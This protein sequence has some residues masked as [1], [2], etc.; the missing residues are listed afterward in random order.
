MTERTVQHGNFTIERHYDVEPARVFEAFADSEIKA[1]WACHDDWGA[2]EFDFS[3]GGREVSRGG[4]PGG[5]V[6]TFDAR[7]HDIVPQRRIIF[8]YDMYRDDTR[9]SVSVAT[10][11]FSPAG[12]GTRLLFTEHGAFL[13]GHDK[14]ETRQHGSGVGLDNLDAFLRGQPLVKSA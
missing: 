3:V 13:D 4:P 2:V 1:Q 8:T 11:E 12:A 14:P 5:P 10:I 6:Y 7:Y 9:L